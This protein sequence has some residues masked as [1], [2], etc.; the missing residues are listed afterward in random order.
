M[1]VGKQHE[2]PG[3]VSDRE[4]PWALGFTLLQISRGSPTN[5]LAAKGSPPTCRDECFQ[6]AW[7]EQTEAVLEG[8]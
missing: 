5:V 8:E 6:T 2:K 4:N 1:V 7:S 3:S